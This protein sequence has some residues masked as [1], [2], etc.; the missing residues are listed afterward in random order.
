MACGEGPCCP[1]G[2]ASDGACHSGVLYVK[3]PL[4]ELTLFGSLSQSGGT[5]QVRLDKANDTLEVTVE[6]EEAE[7]QKS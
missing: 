6:Q 4:A 1:H 5:A 3:K 2:R 7:L